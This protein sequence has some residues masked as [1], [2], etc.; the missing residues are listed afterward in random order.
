M[1]AQFST[2]QYMSVYDCYY[3]IH[4][5]AYLL[6]RFMHLKCPIIAPSR[7]WTQ[8]DQIRLFLKKHFF[9]KKYSKYLATFWGILK[10][11]TFDKRTALTTFV[12]LPTFCSNSWSH[13]SD[14]SVCFSLFSGH[15][16][17]TWISVFFCLFLRMFFA[18]ILFV[19]NRMTRASEIDYKAFSQGSHTPSAATD[20]VTWT[21]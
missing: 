14:F 7:P 13:C 20:T 11:I 4:F 19:L 5:C 18:S 6:P 17:W 15:T 8:C 3:L 21:M 2:A 1:I 12:I 9:S 16:V 10:K